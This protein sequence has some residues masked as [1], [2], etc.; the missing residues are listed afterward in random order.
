L[1][2]CWPPRP[3]LTKPWEGR[4]PRL[5]KS[6][7]IPVKPTDLLSVKNIR[8]GL[9]WEPDG[10]HTRS[11]RF[12][13]E[14]VEPDRLP[15]VLRTLAAITP[16]V[17]APAVLFGHESTRRRRGCYCHAPTTMHVDPSS[18]A[19][20]HGSSRFSEDRMLALF[21]VI[22]PPLLALIFLIR[23]HQEWVFNPGF[24]WMVW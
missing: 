1:L 8:H 16:G 4:F 23:W 22:I 19:G 21:K 17:F 2:S 6:V 20:F 10:S 24:V 13:R 12:H 3:G 15:P 11:D 18:S 7:G 9:G 14:P 5:K